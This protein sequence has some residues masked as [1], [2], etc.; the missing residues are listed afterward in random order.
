[1]QRT[2]ECFLLLLAANCCYVMML[3]PNTIRLSVC[4]PQVGQI[5]ARFT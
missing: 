3:K 5:S 1:M 4:Y 2:L